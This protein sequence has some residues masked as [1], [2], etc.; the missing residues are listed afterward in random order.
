MIQ[1]G[2]AA[3]LLLLQSA[4][5][6][7]S[8]VESPAMVVAKANR[9]RIKTN[10]V[11]QSNPD[12]GFPPA[13]L[14]TGEHGKVTITAIVGVDGHLTEV[15]V[16]VSSRSSLLDAAAVAAA[17]EARFKPALDAKG[18]PLSVALTMDVEFS[19]A[20]SHSTGGGI[21]SYRCDQFARDNDWWAAHWPANQHDD[22]YRLV[23]GYSTMNQSLDANGS[24]DLTRSGSVKDFN[25]RWQGA[26]EAC[27]KAPDKLFIEIFQPEGK[28]LGVAARTW[29][30]P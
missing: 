28:L 3:F 22:F 26:I 10:L 27:R 23:R 13:A 25:T 15:S 6:T 14:A 9:P 2:L 16:T 5:A 11:L 1:Y 20:Q 8:P 18:A 17:T 19:N 12:P 29:L 24:I 21:L 30:R 4:P 7:T